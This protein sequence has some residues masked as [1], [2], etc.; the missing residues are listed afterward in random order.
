VS[1]RYA[2]LN[3]DGLDFTR[4]SS[5]RSP[6]STAAWKA[7]LKLHA[8]LFAQLAHHLPAELT[9]TKAQIEARL[10]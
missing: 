8:E 7:E 2:D 6:A 10:G 3:W 4:A 5:T 1:P 9:A